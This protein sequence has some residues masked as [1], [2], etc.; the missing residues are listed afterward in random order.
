MSAAARSRE[1]ERPQPL[2]TPPAWPLSHGHLCA[3]VYDMAVQSEM[4][5]VRMPADTVAHLETAAKRSGQSRSALIQRYVEEGLR[6]DRHPR[7]TFKDGPSGRRAA[8]IGG[9]DVWEL[10]S[11]VEQLEA[12][13]DEAVAQTAKWFALAIED[14]RAALAYAAEFTEEIRTRIELNQQLLD[15][16]YAAWQA[17]QELL[18]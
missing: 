16:A 5:S 15:E 8:I 11:F 17:Q 4:I 7:I 6:R 1:P 12:R 3:T 18:A 2:A 9:P 14:V 10:M 13:G